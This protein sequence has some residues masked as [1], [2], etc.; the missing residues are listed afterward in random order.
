MSG[1]EQ[2]DTDIEQKMVSLCKLHDSIGNYGKGLRDD[3]RIQT[4]KLGKRRTDISR[5][6][7]FWQ[8]AKQQVTLPIYTVEGQFFF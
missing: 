6:R 1:G 2:L 4:H 8:K 5:C 3:Q 7:V